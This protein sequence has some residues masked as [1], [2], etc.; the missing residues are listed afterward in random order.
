MPEKPRSIEPAKGQG[1]IGGLID[2]DHS[3]A[4]QRNWFALIL[5]AL[6]MILALRL[7]M[8]N[9]AATD[10]FFDEAQ[11]WSWS[12]EPA[13]GYFSKPPLI[14][15]IIGAST[16][17]C[18]ESEFCI[19]LPSPIVH[20]G[21]AL[22]VFWLAS[23]LY[24]QQVGFWAALTF[25]TLPGI[26]LSSG[27][28][29][30]DMPLL[31]AWA[32]ALAALV[33]LLLARG[34]L[35]AVERAPLAKQERDTGGWL[36]ALLLGLALGL[37]LNAKYAMVFFV[38]CG[39][40]Y[41]VL[42]PPA[43]ALLRDPR[44]YLALAIGGVMIVPNILWNL[45]H[46]F[47]TLSHTADNA[48]WGGPMLHPLKA[49]E[50][51]GAQFGVFGPIL[52]GAL[53]VVMWRAWAEGLAPADRLLVAFSVPVIG[54]ILLQALLSRAHANWAATAY[55][56]A[57]VLVVATMIRRADWRWLKGSLVLHMAIGVVIGIGLWQAGKIDLP[58][59]S[60]PFARTLGWKEVAGATRDMLVQAKAAGKPYTGIIAD[61]RS[62]TAE[63]MYYLRDVKLPLRAWKP[64]GSRPHDH[65][66]LTRPF[67]GKLRGPLLL[68]SRTKRARQIASRFAKVRE[69]ARRKIPAGF[70]K[71]RQITFYELSKYR[72]PQI[73]RP[74]N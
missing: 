73:S 10:L 64:A 41:M 45:D 46:G 3:Q 44:L 52:F 33:E 11:Y 38:F 31:F 8:L 67:R 61:D 21:T 24:H 63:L 60:D 37:G 39:A 54:V 55:V 17:L 34:L 35:S 74:S 71:Q 62:L 1:S 4:S 47:A 59:K 22:L 58:G 68:V 26:S 57:S 36:W 56:A 18:G 66:E 53:L 43:R 13:F 51:F 19:R 7:L 49:L 30:T 16:S 70:G 32:L 23:R 69:L 27:I 65:Y 29:S 15:W 42:T 12:L 14:A 25:A 20:T 48:K 40:V 9:Y 2:S 6:A 50:F 28:I 5:V 72:G